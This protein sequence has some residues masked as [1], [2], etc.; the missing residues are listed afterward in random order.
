MGYCMIIKTGYEE[1]LLM[2]EAYSYLRK[3]TNDLQ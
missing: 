2:W 3:N 1:F